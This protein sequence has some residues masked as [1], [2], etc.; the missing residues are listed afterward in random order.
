VSG[1]VLNLNERY[2]DVEF[3]E[4]LLNI[5][6]KADNNIYMSGEVSEIKKIIDNIGKVDMILPYFIDKRNTIRKIISKIF[7]IIL[8]IITI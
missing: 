1:A 4:G 6:W 7:I 8:K 5:D 2:V 3:Q